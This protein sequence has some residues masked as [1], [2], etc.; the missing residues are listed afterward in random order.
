[1]IIIIDDIHNE[2]HRFNYNN[3]Q[4][5]YYDYDYTTLDGLCISA[6]RTRSLLFAA[7]PGL[8]CL[9]KTPG[10]IVIA[11]RE[12]RPL[13][14]SEGFQFLLYSVLTEDILCMLDS[15]IIYILIL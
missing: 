15:P 8:G 1:V 9:R 2:D 4:P 5:Y 3:Y 13:A 11:A 6:T 10:H 14:L 12:T 7:I